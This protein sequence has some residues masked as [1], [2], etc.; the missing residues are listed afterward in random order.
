MRRPRRN[1]ASSRD[2]RPS[3]SPRSSGTKP[4]SGSGTTR[5]SSLCRTETRTRP[6]Y[7]RKGRKGRLRSTPPRREAPWRCVSPNTS[8]GSRRFGARA[9]AWAAFVFRPGRA[10]SPLGTGPTAAP[11]VAIALAFASNPE[12]TFYAPVVVGPARR[13]DDARRRRRRRGPLP[14]PRPRLLRARVGGR[15]VHPGDARRAAKHRGPETAAPRDG[16]GGRR[17]RAARP[18]RR[19]VRRARGA[20]VFRRAGRGV[21]VTTGGDGARVRR[22]RGVG[23]SGG[24][25]RRLE[26]PRS[27]RPRVRRRHRP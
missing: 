16:R 24:R 4:R 25:R 19:L 1:S 27:A 3:R 8:S 5:R 17:R 2:S 10:G 7:R 14:R 9:R 18:R 12:A 21:A 22:R 26:A 15:A 20:S 23:S 6:V 11:P 13:G